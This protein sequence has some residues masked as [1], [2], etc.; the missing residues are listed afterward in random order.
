MNIFQFYQATKMSLMF[1]H[2]HWQY[3][4]MVKYL[5]MIFFG[6]KCVYL[7]PTNSKTVGSFTS[8]SSLTLTISEVHFPRL[9]RPQS[10]AV[11][12]SLSNYQKKDAH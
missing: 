4:D 12:I 2:K 9:Q 1:S 3:L 11:L 7:F 8:N 10:T 5:Y 6:H